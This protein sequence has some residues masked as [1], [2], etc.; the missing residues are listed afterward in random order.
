M[1]V[2]LVLTKEVYDVIKLLIQ[3]HIRLS[4]G[5]TDGPC[6]HLKQKMPEPISQL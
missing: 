2:R 3:Q 6:L 4:S 1:A 5:V